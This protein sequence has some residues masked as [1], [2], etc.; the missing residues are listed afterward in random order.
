MYRYIVSGFTRRVKSGRVYRYTNEYL[1]VQ[2][3]LNMRRL[4]FIEFVNLL[5]PD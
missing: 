3:D 5:I 4:L 1:D 2:A